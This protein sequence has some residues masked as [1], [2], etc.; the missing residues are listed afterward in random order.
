A[1]PAE[2]V[3]AAT[4]PDPTRHDRDL[5]ETAAADRLR[6]FPEEP[7]V[8]FGRVADATGVPALGPA[9]YAR[10]FEAVAVVAAIPDLDFNE[11]ARQIRDALQAEG[12]TVSRAQVNFVLNVFRQNRIEIARLDAGSLAAAWRDIT[13]TALRNA[14]V[15]LSPEELKL[16]DRW[17]LGGGEPVVTPADEPPAEDEAPAPLA[18]PVEAGTE[19]A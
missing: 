13:L 6:D 8:F 3:D 9:E 2:R 4:T 18:P 10:L 15:P 19:A 16:I 12:L 1:I 5:I 17:L 7:E 14:L 11:R